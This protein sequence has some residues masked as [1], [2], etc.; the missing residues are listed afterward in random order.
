MDKRFQYGFT[1]I[2]VITIIVVIGILAGVGIFSYTAI[3]RDTRDT[4]R[5]TDAETLSVALGSWARNNNQTPI[6]TGGGYNGGGEGW[7][8][9]S[10]TGYGGA[11]IES[12][13]IDDE[14]LNGP[15][16]APRPPAGTN[17]FALFACDKSETGEY[18]YGVFMLLE[19]PRGEDQAEMNRWSSECNPE[20]L[21]A[22]YNLNAVKAFSFRQ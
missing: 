17:G 4:Q 12:V 22:P 6:Q 18:R 9:G 8:R 16:E 20:P 14:Y 3:T 5:R 11:N 19:S 21:N 2:E 1:I 13:L 10:G 7:I 15:V